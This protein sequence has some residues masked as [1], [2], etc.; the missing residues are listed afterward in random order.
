MKQIIVLP[1]LFFCF[2]SFAQK[3]DTLLV[4]DD[5]FINLQYN[6]AVVISQSSQ[7]TYFF[8]ESKSNVLFIQALQK[9]IVESNLFVQTAEGNIYNYIVKYTPRLHKIVYNYTHGLTAVPRTAPESYISEVQQYSSSTLNPL[10]KQKGYINSRNRASKGG[11][12]LYLKGVYTNADKLYLL[13]QLVN[14]SNLNYD[15]S[16]IKLFI[17]PISRMKNI[18]M[19]DEEITPIVY[20]SVNKIVPQ[21]ENYITLEIN[22]TALIDKVISVESL[23]RNGDRN[24]NINV[25]QDYITNA[26]S[27]KK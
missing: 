7:P 16:D 6:S 21:G 23:E 27:L 20:N 9:N 3:I 17:R 10:E 2:S 12:N 14:K 15:I 11:V 4:N 19:Q 26:K 18:A 25:E 5:K 24:L 8:I 13:I 22:K 1:I